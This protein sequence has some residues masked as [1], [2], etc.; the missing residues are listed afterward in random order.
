MLGA[1][2][3]RPAWA[4]ARCEK[5]NHIYPPYAGAKPPDFFFFFHVRTT[6]L[7]PRVMRLSIART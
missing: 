2:S 4:C 3:E 5:K 6:P 7:F 1:C